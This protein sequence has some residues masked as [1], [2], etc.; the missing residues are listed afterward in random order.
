MKILNIHGYRGSCEN[1]SFAA[2]SALG[3]EMISPQIDYDKQSPD[4]ILLFLNNL[5]QQH[6]CQA[7]VGTSLGGFYAALLSMK[8]YA[9]TVLIN[10]CLLPFLLL[11][12]IEESQNTLLF[13][14]L[15]LFADI[16]KIDK[17]QILAIIGEQ[18]EVI[19]THDFT[20]NLLGKSRCICVPD[21]KHSGWTLP[22]IDIFQQ[23][24]SWLCGH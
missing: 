17:N 20:Q 7:I 1:S 9:K 22:L 12:Q 21:G 19:S 4:E 16:I 5:W 10:P 13:D 24:Y 2:L 18:D 15:R 23:Q 3:A 14:Y 6:N 8:H 11:P